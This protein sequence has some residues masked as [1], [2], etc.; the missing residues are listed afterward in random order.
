MNSIGT[1]VTVALVVAVFGLL[2]KQGQLTRFASFVGD[3]REELQKCTW[4]NR[5]ELAGSTL[6]VFVTI[7]LLGGFTFVVDVGLTYFV[8][9]L[10]SL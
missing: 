5:Q 2:W 8:R 4:P 10:A 1:I 7:G 3:T 9:L 6:V